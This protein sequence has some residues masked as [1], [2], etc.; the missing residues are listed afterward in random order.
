MELAARL[1]GGHDAEL[2]RAALGI[3]LNE[4]ALAAAL[5]EPADVPEPSPAGGAC[6]RFLVP[7]EG[8]LTALSGLDE[9]R[10]ANG[11]VDARRLPAP[12][13]AS[14][15]RF[16]GA[17][18]APASCSRGA[19]PGTTRSPKRAARPTSYASRPPMQ[20]SSSET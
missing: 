19:T 11:V 13:L 16:V 20:L 3:D 15:A 4:L 6:V 5:G 9:A 8:V 7:P 14:S 12:R 17:P 2:C 10:A 18:I 1:G